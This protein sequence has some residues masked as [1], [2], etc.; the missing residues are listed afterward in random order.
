MNVRVLIHNPDSSERS[1]VSHLEGTLPFLVRKVL[2]A[3]TEGTGHIASTV[4]EQR[5]M[6]PHPT[7]PTPSSYAC[8]ARVQRTALPPRRV[9][10]P[11]SVASSG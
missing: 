3:G 11:S 1:F 8:E 4:R 6:M 9:D 10:L 5:A 7:D 2:V